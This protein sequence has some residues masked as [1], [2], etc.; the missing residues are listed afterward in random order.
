MDKAQKRQPGDNFEKTGHGDDG[1]KNENSQGRLTLHKSHR[2]EKGSRGHGYSEGYRSSKKGRFSDKT[3]RPYKAPYAKS[4]R[5]HAKPSHSYTH[6]TGFSAFQNRLVM[7]ILR[8]VLCAGKLLDRAY[9]Y[10]FSKVKIDPVEQ[11][12]IIRNVNAMFQRLS[13]YA[14][15]AGLKRPSDFQN[16][17]GRLL[18]T[19]CEYMRWTLPEITGEENFDRQG[20]KKRMGEA[21]NDPLLNQGC[22]LW[23]D[24]IGK[25]ELV[26]KWETER[27]ALSESPKRFIRT[28]TLKTTRGYQIRKR[29]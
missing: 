26:D 11:G 9:A 15:A 23:L 3:S 20:I 10:W 12:F 22:P 27:K 1:L 21:Q 19:Y 17:P 6:H 25:K 29:G 5:G 18:F 4:S 14:Y 24:E 13:F 28:N 7:S 16:H 8:D 2:D